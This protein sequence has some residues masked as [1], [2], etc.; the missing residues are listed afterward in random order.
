MFKAVNPK[1]SMIDEFMKMGLTSLHN[2]VTQ[3]KYVREGYHYNRKKIPLQLQLFFI[4]CAYVDLNF[5]V[6]C[7][8]VN[9]I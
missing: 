3:Q 5:S 2:I 1:C 9:T 6:C 8:V 7:E 4:S